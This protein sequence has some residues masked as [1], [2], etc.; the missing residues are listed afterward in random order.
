MKT[1]TLL[2]LLSLTASASTVH[3]NESATSLEDY[4]AYCTEQAQLAG[5]EDVDELK[6]YVQD[7]VESYAG[8]AGE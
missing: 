4:N 5:I 1:A 7:C 8:P 6:Q 2:I 3:A